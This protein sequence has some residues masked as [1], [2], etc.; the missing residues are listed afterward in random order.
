MD[1]KTAA[2]YNKAPSDPSSRRMIAFRALP[3]TI[4][5]RHLYGVAGA[6]GFDSFDSYADWTTI[7]SDG[8]YVLRR[9]CQALPCFLIY[10]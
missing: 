2:G 1:I 9:S 5:N 8:V 10:Y 3:G 7:S 4:S 6:I